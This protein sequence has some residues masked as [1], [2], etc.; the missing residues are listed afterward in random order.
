MWLFAR[1]EQLPAAA[2]DAPDS[3]LQYSQQQQDEQEG[4]DQRPAPPTLTGP[5]RLE[6]LCRQLCTELAEMAAI[7]SPPPHRASSQQQQ[8]QQRKPVVKSASS[9]VALGSASQLVPSATS[10]PQQQLWCSE[11]ARRVLSLLLLA[12]LGCGAAPLSATLNAVLQVMSVLWGGWGRG[13]PGS[14]GM[15]LISHLPI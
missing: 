6:P 3:Q 7:P 15:S 9:I 4:G 12:G 11:P 14:C 1:E 5:S 13:G 8:Q 10:Q 2:A